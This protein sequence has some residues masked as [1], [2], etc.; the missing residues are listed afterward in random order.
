MYKRFPNQYLYL[1][2]CLIISVLQW[3]Q[4]VL[5]A[6]DLIDLF[7][8]DIKDWNYITACHLNIWGNWNGVV[9]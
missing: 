8:R 7:R 5:A 4:F 2:T 9:G 1:S 3:A 6:E